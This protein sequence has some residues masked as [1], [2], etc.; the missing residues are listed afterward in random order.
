MSVG[1][2]KLADTYFLRQSVKCVALYYLAPRVGEEA[3]T[4]ALKVVVDD[5]AHDCIENCVAKKFKTF[6]VYR[7][8][9]AVALLYALV[10]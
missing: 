2:D 8:P 5:V 9:F 3:L 4:L 7:A 1:H 10:H 6:V